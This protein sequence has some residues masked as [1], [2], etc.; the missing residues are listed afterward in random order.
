M[1]RIVMIIDY[2]KVGYDE[3]W[4]LENTSKYIY[5]PLP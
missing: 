2:G 4:D 3:Y 1:R 5:K